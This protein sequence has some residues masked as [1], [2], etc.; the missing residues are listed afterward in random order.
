[1]S[2]FTKQPES[3]YN[4][5]KPI[6]FDSF[7]DTNRLSNNNPSHHNCNAHMGEELAETLVDMMQKCTLEKIKNGL[8][9]ETAVAETIVEY[10]QMP[11][12]GERVHQAYLKKTKHNRNPQTR[13]P[14]ST[15]RQLVY[16]WGTVIILV[17]LGFWGLGYLGSNNHSTSSSSQDSSAFNEP[18]QTRLPTGLEEAYF[19]SEANC[20]MSIT[21]SPSDKND[22]YIKF[23]DASNRLTATVYIRS[24]GTSKFQ[25]PEGTYRMKY[26]YGKTWYG[27]KYY[28]GPSGGYSQADSLIKCYS[29]YEGYYG[30][31][32]TLYPVSN[33]NLSTSNISKAQFD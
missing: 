4:V 9:V 29:T 25:M 5:K 8:D 19:K 33:G 20:P 10:Q 18:T 1:M 30:S 12:L 7:R 21:L 6:D 11:D 15:I 26:A 16:A 32:I 2:P 17:F 28:F 13:K 27:K 24:G 22:Y 23:I 31:T 3:D 14:M